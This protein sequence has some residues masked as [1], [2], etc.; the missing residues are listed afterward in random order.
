MKRTWLI[1]LV[2]FLAAPAWA[3]DKEVVVGLYLP[4]L[5][6]VSRAQRVKAV[7]DLAAYLGSKIGQPV[8]G[9]SFARAADLSGAIRQ[10]QVQLAIV[11]ALLVAE[12]RWT[13]MATLVFRGAK[14][15]PWQ[16]LA[17]AGSSIGDLKGKTLAFPGIGKADRQFVANVLL[18]GE[19][20]ASYFTWNT[21]P[22]GSSA[23]RA[24]ALGKAVATVVPAQRGTGG[25]STVFVSRDVPGPAMVN[26]GR[27]PPK[28]SQA[29]LQALLGWSGSWLGY[30]GWKP[31]EAGQYQHLAGS[32]TIS[33]LA[34]KPIVPKPQP[35]ALQTRAVLAP[36]HASTELPS[37]LGLIAAPQ[38]RP[39]APGA[40]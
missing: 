34:R 9:R 18:E 28:V 14:S 31:A 8:K 24:V 13:P 2:S 27:L 16:F 40:N 33:K 35:F 10:H 23:V 15:A 32:L 20:P 29:V 7:E 21:S 39:D 1:L 30:E 19:V 37:L 26:A 17:K 22:D 5:S 3:Q 6:D 11:D 4:A 38:V 12:R 36:F 25:L